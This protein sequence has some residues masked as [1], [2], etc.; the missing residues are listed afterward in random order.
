M[1]GALGMPTRREEAATTYPW[2]NECG[3][4]GISKETRA[5][6]EISGSLR[7]LGIG[8]TDGAN[9]VERA[10]GLPNFIYLNPQLLGI[11]IYMIISIRI[12]LD[13]DTGKI[14]LINEDGRKLEYPNFF[15]DP[16]LF[17][18]VNGIITRLYKKSKGQAKLSEY[19]MS[20]YRY[21]RLWFKFLS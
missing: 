19:K 15:Q 1:E 3:N 6:C 5:K 18:P 10:S 20:V 17:D 9:W 4:K 16:E 2:L 7:N 21:L 8:S 12:I 14:F 11:V 13:P